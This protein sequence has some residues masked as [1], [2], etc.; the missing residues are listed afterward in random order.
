MASMSE[1]LTQAAEAA[2]RSR[3]AWLAAARSWIHVAT[4]GKDYPS[5]LA[6][7]TSGLALWTGRLAYADPAWTLTQGPN[8]AARTPESLAPR[9]DDLRDVVSVLHHTSDALEQLATSNVQH[10]T[11]SAETGGFYAARHTYRAAGDPGLAFTRAHSSRVARILDAYH[12]A[13]Q[14]SAHTTQAAARNAA[15]IHAPSTVLTTLRTAQ[16]AS[17]SAKP[18]AAGAGW[19]IASRAAAEPLDLPGHFERTLHEL[20]ENNPDALR[21]AAAI[22][23]AGEQLLIQIEHTKQLKNAIYKSAGLTT[24]PGSGSQLFIGRS[25]GTGNSM[26]QQRSAAPGREAGL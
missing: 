10:I 12:A 3:D 14:A 19:Q 26:R 20:G 21:R 18:G 17:Q 7:E 9:L 16:W 22:D 25:S 6:A 15:A 8:R 24:A 23:L 1:N 13:A 2:G 5:A 11:A 4:H